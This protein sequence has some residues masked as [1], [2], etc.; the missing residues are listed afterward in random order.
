MELLKISGKI[1][2]LEIK[3]PRALNFSVDC[4]RWWRKLDEILVLDW[5]LDFCFYEDRL[6]KLNYQLLAWRSLFKFRT[7]DRCRAHC[8]HLVVPQL[9]NYRRVGLVQQWHWQMTQIVWLGSTGR[10][11]FI[12]LE[13]WVSLD[14]AYSPWVELGQVLILR[15]LRITLKPI[16]W[17]WVVVVG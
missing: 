5:R 9:A 4:C 11:C 6:L 16:Q 15:L 8:L 14:K 1:F 7:I 10:Y 17:T 3:R 2:L 13:H 12:L